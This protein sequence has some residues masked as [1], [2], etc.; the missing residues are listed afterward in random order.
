MAKYIYPAVFEPNELGGYCVFF[1]DLENVFTQGEDLHNAMA[2]AEDALC[3]MLYDME[4]K[5]L[6]IPKARKQS[7][8]K[9]K[10]GEII[11][12]IACDTQ[13]YKNYF[14]GKSVKVSASMPMWL[15]EAGDKNNINF[16]Q[17]LQKAVKEYLNLQ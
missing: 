11:N 13:F 2:M 14:E 15:K 1:P 3:L 17:M 8:I 6:D 10:Q 9:T 7:D 4:K 12:L 5:G 16:S